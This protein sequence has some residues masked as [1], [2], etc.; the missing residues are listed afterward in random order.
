MSDAKEGT[1]YQI[2][3]RSSGEI[4]EQEVSN[5]L[6][7]M[8]WKLYDDHSEADFKKFNSTGQFYIHGVY[9]LNFLQ[10]GALTDKLCKAWPSRGNKLLPT[11]D[12]DIFFSG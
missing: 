8:L 7:E 12:A 5:R 10:S 9:V 3:A 4:I 2:Y 11:S 6:S 1:G